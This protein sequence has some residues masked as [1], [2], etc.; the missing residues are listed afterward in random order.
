VLDQAIVKIAQLLALGFGEA[1]GFIIK[2]NMNESED[3]NPLLPG[4]RTHAIFGFATI[5]NFV[6]TTEVLQEEV[7]SYVN[8]IAEIVHSMV[9][10]YGGAT[11]KNI[12]EAFL[13]VWNFHDS[14]E[15]ERLAE[16]ERFF[17]H[18]VSR[19]NQIVADMSLISILKI[20]SKINSYEH[21]Q[22]YNNH[23][24]LS[25]KVPDFRVRM[26]FGLH[27][28]WAI[29]GA[30]GSFFKIDV[31]YLSPNVNLASRLGAATK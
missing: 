16:Q 25:L 2:H 14:K 3:F 7:M 21:I 11:N 13:M 20:I 12:G 5:D 6:A 28:G 15:M 10:R 30:I 1:G 23:K 8:K 31:S 17:N 19:E 18:Q 29:Q 4:I 9:D 24:D 26:G 22:E 27:H